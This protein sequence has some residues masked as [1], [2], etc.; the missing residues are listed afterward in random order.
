MSHSC[1]KVDAPP[2]TS[3]PF[4]RSIALFV[5]ESN[6]TTAYR[7]LII[8]NISLR[9]WDVYGDHPHAYLSAQIVTKAAH[10]Q[11]G[12]NAAATTEKASCFM[13]FHR[14]SDGDFVYQDLQAHPESAGD[15]HVEDLQGYEDLNIADKPTLHQFLLLCAWSS[16]SCGPYN[17]L[18]GGNCIQW[19]G[20]IWCMMA[21]PVFHRDHR[22]LHLDER[23]GVFRFKRGPSEQARAAEYDRHHELHLKFARSLYRDIRGDYPVAVTMASLFSPLGILIGIDTLARTLSEKVKQF[24]GKK[25]YV[26]GISPNFAE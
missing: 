26:E 17:V 6:T 2:P 19:T 3:A 5:A 12:D 15:K 4:Q 20:R 13:T 25:L 23:A 24:G 8:Y 9:K 18:R 16:Q 7:S 10:P 21:W 14:F 1:H 11:Q 22:A